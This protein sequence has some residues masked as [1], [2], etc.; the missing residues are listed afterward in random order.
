MFSKSALREQFLNKR[1]AVSDKSVI[2]K[3]RQIFNKII[4]IK[5]LNK[6]GNFLVYLP[7]QNEVDTGQIIEY[8]FW[9][10]SSVFVPAFIKSNSRFEAVEF[11]ASDQLETGPYQIPQPKNLRPVEIDHID[12]AIIPGVA[13][14]KLGTRLGYGKGVY[15]KLL[16]GFSGLKIGLSYDF[17]FLEKLPKERHDM[18]MDMVFTEN[19][20]YR[21]I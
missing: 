20:I 11:T 12:A 1:S 15:D 13:F 5:Q 10:K 6:T 14:D 2:F 8:L 17:Q 7:V 21:V 19:N 9:R 3:S 16:D 4:Q 18:V